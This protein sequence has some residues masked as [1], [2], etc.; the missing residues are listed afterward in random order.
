L[1]NNNKSRKTEDGTSK[2]FPHER[3]DILK[4]GDYISQA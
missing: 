2:T 4:E 3:Q 1:E